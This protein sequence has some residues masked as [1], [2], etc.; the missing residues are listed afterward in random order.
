M[1]NASKDAPGDDF[2]AFFV[3]RPSGS[4]WAPVTDQLSPKTRQGGSER[5][6]HDLDVASSILRQPGTNPS[7]KDR[8]WTFTGHP[9]NRNI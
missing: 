4:F 9:R 5:S 7:E 8:E 3:L 1:L 6:S 2:E